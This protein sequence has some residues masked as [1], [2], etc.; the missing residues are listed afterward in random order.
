VRLGVT[1]VKCESFRLY[2]CCWS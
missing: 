1:E 2:L